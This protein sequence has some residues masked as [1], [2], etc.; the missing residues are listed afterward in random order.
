MTKENATEPSEQLVM[1][2]V[3]RD[4]GVEPVSLRYQP[5]KGDV[6]SV[7]IHRHEEEE[8]AALL[9]GRGWRIV[10]DEPAA[11]KDRAS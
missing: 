5:R 10:A 2:M 11:A 9:R 1:L 4:R 8:A 6:V 7:A 3:R